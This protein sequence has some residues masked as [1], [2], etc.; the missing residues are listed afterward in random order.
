MDFL[1]ISSVVY[2]I[3]KLVSRK[4]AYDHWTRSLTVNIPIWKPEPWVALAAGF[5]ECISFLTGDEWR[6]SFSQAMREI[7]QRDLKRR[8]NYRLLS[9]DAVSLFSGGLD[10]LIG[11]IDWLSSTEEQ[12]LHLVGHH[13]VAVKGPMSDQTKLYQALRS[14]YRDRVGI[15]QTRIGL[16]EKGDE[17]SFRSRSLIFLALAAYVAEIIGVTTPVYMPENGPISLNPPLNPSRRGSCS[18]RTAHPHFF[19]TLQEIWTEVGLDHPIENPYRF[20]TKGE[21]V[22]ECRDQDLLELCYHDSV[23]CAKSGH[24]VHWENPTAGACGRC[25]P[26]LFRRASLHT[27]N[28]DNQVYGYDVLSEAMNEERLG[29]DL[30]ALLA[31]LRRDPSQDEIAQMLTANGPVPFDDLDEY[32]AL[33]GRMKAELADWIRAKGPDFVKRKAG[34]R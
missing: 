29:D 1:F 8:R 4:T 32:S 21:I 23:S 34:L 33:I 31:F 12:S 10:S 28:L 11:A 19:A 20:K 26:C 16:V 5:S 18:T 9:A 15:L 13:D 17:I 2:G 24:T 14:Q 25:V 30:R 27:V 22:S 7:P 6:I 3:D